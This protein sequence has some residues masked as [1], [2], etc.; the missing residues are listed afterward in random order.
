MDMTL[1]ADDAS[2]ATALH[3]ALD[4]HFPEIDALCRERLLR[5][6]GLLREWN[7]RLNLISH[8]DEPHLLERHLLPSLAFSRVV[9]F[10]PGA[11]VLDVGTGGGL[12]GLPLAILF[13][14]TRFVL[15]DS[16]GK[17]IRAVAAMA[18]AL[19]LEQVET[20]HQR[21]ETLELQADYVVARSV[22]P[23]GR[24]FSWTA[25]RIRPGRAGSRDNG[26][27]YLRGDDYADEVAAGTIPEPEVTPLERLLPGLGLEE[28][29]LLYF[30]VGPGGRP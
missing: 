11:V 14:E 20:R 23:L 2:G 3:A 24:F 15:L 4:R 21:V 7:S 13:P 18:A 5:W 29:H 6:S 27:I 1:P 30:P 16:V 12:P 25:G 28:K 9:R 22:A 26:W 17:K 8:R 10:D 19:G